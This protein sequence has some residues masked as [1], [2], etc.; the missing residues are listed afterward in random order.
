M[1]LRGRPGG[2]EN[3]WGPFR[4]SDLV[5]EIIITEIWVIRCK[6][7]GVVPS[8]DKI[9]RPLKA[10]LEDRQKLGFGQTLFVILKL[11]F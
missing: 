4:N 8:C 3:I 2:E 9:I 1:S 5:R 10:T 6:K 11:I 7:N